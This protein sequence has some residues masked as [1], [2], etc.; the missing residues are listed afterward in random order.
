MK[1]ATK[2]PSKWT[3]FKSSY[4]RLSSDDEEIAIIEDNAENV[5]NYGSEGKKEKKKKI[6]KQASKRLKKATW[7]ALKAI[8]HGFL[9]SSYQMA[10]TSTGMPGVDPMYLPH[11]RAPGSAFGTERYRYHA[12]C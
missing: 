4:R 12:K 1:Q 9:Y 11:L 8:Y 3:V 2:K 10:Y 7:S 6:I 5:P